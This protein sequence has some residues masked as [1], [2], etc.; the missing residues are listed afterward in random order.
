[1]TVEIKLT[2]GLTA[3]VDDED[4]DLANMRWHVHARPLLNYVKRRD[5]VDGKYVNVYLHRVVLERMLGRSLEEGEIVD[6]ASHDGL[7][8][9]RCNLRLAS[10]HENMGNRRHNKNNA[11]G[12]KGVHWLKARNKWVARVGNKYL[13]LFTSPIDAARAYNEAAI[14]HFGPYA[15][16]NIIP[17]EA[18]S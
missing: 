11:S 8:N 17:D 13:G 15:F 1:M 14:K 10:A 6:H 5:L 2:K 16:L 9:R 12:F 7:D 4:S 3:I 18:Q